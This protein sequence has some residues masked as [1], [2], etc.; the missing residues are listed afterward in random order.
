MASTISITAV[1]REAGLRLLSTLVA[2]AEPYADEAEYHIVQSYADLLQR[3]PDS[4]STA[5][6]SAQHE[7]RHRD[8]ANARWLDAFDELLSHGGEMTPD[9]AEN[10]WRAYLLHLDSAA[11]LLWEQYRKMQRNVM[12]ETGRQLPP[13][14]R[15]WLNFIQAFMGLFESRL[16]ETNPHFQTLF[17]SNEARILADA[18]LAGAEP[19]ERSHPPVTFGG[20]EFDAAAMLTAYLEWCVRLVGRIDPH[21]YQHSFNPTLPLGDVFVPLRITRLDGHTLPLN[22]VRYQAPSFKVDPPPG[23]QTLP[24]ID[25]LDDESSVAISEAL[26]ENRRLLLL[27][28]S[29]AGKTILLQHLAL[30]YAQIAIEDIAARGL[31]SN[32]IVQPSRQ[33][34]IYVRLGYYIER[35]EPEEGLTSYIVRMVTGELQGAL[36]PGLLTSLLEEGRC[37]VLLDGL[38]EVVNDNQRRTLAASVAAFADKWCE[39]GNRVVVSCRLEGY[40]AMSLPASFAGYVIHPLDRSQIGL[41]LIK[42]LLAL[43]HL[44]RSSDSDDEISRRAQAQ[45]LSLLRELTSSPQLDDLAQN[46]LILR[47]L[48]SI[49]QAGLRLPSQRVLLYEHMADA[50]IRVWRLP[51]RASQAPKVLERE[52]MALLGELAYW[53]QAYRPTGT[54]TD[55]EL[56]DILERVWREQHLNATSEDADEAV[57]CFLAEVR[58]RDGVLAEIEPRHYGF[59]CHTLQEYFAARHLV[60][61]FR[62][63]ARR[64]R[65]HLHDPRWEEVIL[66]AI[67]FI[68]QSYPVDA[69]ELVTYAVL[70]DDALAA[71]RG[72]EPSPYE[73][74]LRRDLFLAA[75]LLCEEIDIGAEVAQ[76][77]VDELVTLWVNADRDSAGRFRLVTDGVRRYLMKLDGTLTGQYAFQRTLRYLRADNE[78]VR[79]YAIDALTFWPSYSEEVCEALAGVSLDHAPPLVKLAMACALG[80]LR[81]LSSRGYVVLLTLIRDPDPRV[82]EAAQGALKRSRS[83]PEV[84]LRTWLDLLRGDTSAKRRMG[85]K[86]LQDVGVLPPLVIGELLRLLSDPNPDVRE[87]VAGALSNAPNLPENALTSICRA[88]AD[89]H[90]EVQLAAIRAL[91]RPVKLPQEVIDHLIMWTQA[92]SP[93]I[94]RAAAN[95]LGV[96]ENDADDVLRALERLV[97]DPVD[98]VRQPAVEMLAQKGHDDAR[99]VHLLTHTARDSSHSVRIGLARALREFKRP[100]EMVRRTI[101][102]LLGDTH[103]GV[104]EAILESIAQMEDPGDEIVRH[105]TGLV[106]ASDRTANEPVLVALSGLR[107]LPADTLITMIEMLPMVQQPAV[108]EVILGCVKAHMPARAEEIA[109]PLLDVALGASGNLKP[110]VINVLGTAIHAAG[111]ILEVLLQLV[112]EESVALQRAA[113]A[114]LAYARQVPPHTVIRLLDLLGD[115]NREVRL[116]AAVALA[117]LTRHLPDID[118]DHRQTRRLAETLYCLLHELPPRAAWETEGVSQ[119]E[120]LYA[121][122]W[123]AYRL[124]PGRLQLPAG[125]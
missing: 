91:G 36:S 26:Q 46:P 1:L 90:E 73:D 37:L 18:T 82:R 15:D 104:R 21:G 114:S 34:P 53:L 23:L 89:T 41:F 44:D 16:F 74:V 108:V 118:L 50:L 27:G 68:A 85:A 52:A 107:H 117:R 25:E 12:I 60:A 101:L 103:L 39:H 96:S 97:N 94:R 4:I 30:E 9:F 111:G 86:M 79:A 123:V 43:E 5:L 14:W 93:A 122:N 64:I 125:T 100:D 51:Q 110:A 124:R 59:V 72:Y 120:A 33:I 2:R 3:D 109:Y 7:L 63:S 54:A 45:T 49:Q 116:A 98:T 19:V 62:M 83:I 13:S 106:R 6:M 38:N 20:G 99:V 17:L 10:L 75:R 84:A 56:R 105:L 87:A 29:G 76:R 48:I 58:H 81:D 35:R 92:E 57:E 61:S 115:E 102:V 69:A 119:N 71:S 65:A 31:D 55:Q 42:W 113:I 80:R 22:F 121:L 47:M 95:A 24:D 77:V 11:A 40:H 32:T 67:G 66:L 8:P 78:A 28:E 112:D 70:A 88:I